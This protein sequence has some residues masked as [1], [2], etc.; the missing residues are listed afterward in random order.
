VPFEGFDVPVVDAQGNRLPPGEVGEILIWNVHHGYFG[1]PEESRAAFHDEAYGGRWEGYQHTGDLGVYDEDGYL[2]V[3]GRKKDMILRGGQNIFPKEIEDLLSEHPDVRDIAVVGMPDPVL[4]E[5][6]CA[7][8]VPREGK[9]PGV[10]DFASFLDERGVARFK[11]PERVELVASLPLGP[12]GK[13][14]KDVLR[15]TIQKK[16]ALE[17]EARS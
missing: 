2:R 6:V 3:V 5:R 7:F 12:G 11:W 15:E 1:D 9:A 13:V 14:R 4:G 8:V 17:E 16:L 10:A